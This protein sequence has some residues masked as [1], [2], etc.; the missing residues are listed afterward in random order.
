MFKYI[1]VCIPAPMWDIKQKF[2]SHCLLEEMG[3]HQTNPI[4]ELLNQVLT[5]LQIIFLSGLSTHTDWSLLSLQDRLLC[6]TRGITSCHT[7]SN[8]CR[9]ITFSAS[10]LNRTKL[11][12]ASQSWRKTRLCVIGNVS[13]GISF[14]PQQGRCGSEWQAWSGQP[15]GW[16]R[17][18]WEFPAWE[19]DQL[20]SSLWHVNFSYFSHRP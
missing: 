10:S 1:C 8:Q 15:W 13:K 12:P 19:L 11:L 5:V 4:E 14:Y 2:K 9:K 7:A 17:P 18:L 16:R 6:S 3:K 20:S